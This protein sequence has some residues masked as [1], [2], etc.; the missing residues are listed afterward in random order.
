MLQ[1]YYLF[2]WRQT[3]NLHKY[4]EFHLKK[5]LGLKQPVRTNSGALSRDICPLDVRHCKPMCISENLL[6]QVNSVSIVYFQE[7][8]PRVHNFNL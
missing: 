1:P 3:K 5:S 2:F 4:S 8:K 7:G 6:Y